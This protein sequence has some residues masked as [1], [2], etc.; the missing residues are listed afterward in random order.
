MLICARNIEQINFDALM[1]IYEEGNIENGAYFFPEQSVEQQHILAVQAFRK[2]LE[3]DFFK[4]KDAQYWI[5]TDGRRYI[6]ALR[7]EAHAEGLLMEALE[8]RP[9]CR[10]QGFAKKLIQAVLLRLSSG[11][12]VYSHVSKKNAASIAT[13]L[14]CGF[15]KYLDYVPEPDGSRYEQ[16][17]TFLVRA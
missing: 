1:E 12:R 16:D 13:H 10:K 9:D 3:E 15:H 6:S 5:Q 2:Y 7:L 17:I 11:T 4:Q 8:T 14:S